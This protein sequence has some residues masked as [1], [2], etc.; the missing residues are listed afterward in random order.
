MRPLRVLVSALS[1]LLLVPVGTPVAS[2]ASY[3]DPVSITFPTAPGVRYGNDYHDGRSGGRRHLSTDLLGARGQAVHAAQA[4]TVV[5]ITASEHASA[6]WGMQVRGTDN[7][8]YAYY[9]LGNARGSRSS[10]FVAGMAKGTRLARGQQIGFLGDSGNARGTPHLHFEIH[11][12]RVRDPYGGNRVNP[13]ASLRAAERRGDYPRGGTTASRSR[14]APTTSSGSAVLRRGDRGSA[15]KA[16]QADLNRVSTTKIA[17]DGVFGPSTHEATRAFQRRHKLTA[18]GIV[19]RATRAAMDRAKGAGGS[20]TTTTPRA[21]PV[22]RRGD[23]GPAVQRWQT[24]LNRVR[25]SSARIATD[26]IFGPGTDAATRAFQRRHKLTADGIVGRAT[27]AA[28]T[29]ARS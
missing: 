10:A 25:G 9:H 8:L 1:A 13:Y 5:W 17:A 4:G 18:D 12:S 23:Q 27:R 29:R 2:A 3:G 11:D 16:W 26:G 22:L 28:M 14:T 6:G 7:R 21:E 19:G 24:D 15:V 20:G